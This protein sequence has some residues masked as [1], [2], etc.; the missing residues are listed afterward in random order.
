TL[1]SLDLAWHPHSRVIREDQ[2]GLSSARLRGIQE[3]SADL[4]VFVDDDNVLAQDYLWQAI[5]IEREWPMLGVWGSGVIAPEFEEEP[6]ENLRDYLPL[7]SLRYT[8]SAQWSNF[9]PDHGGLPWGAGQC[10]RAIVAA[11]YRDYFERPGI[12]MSDR[13]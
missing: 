4:L 6:A 2:L 11:A 7:L 3:A 5:R 13:Q 9:L 12:K 1:E 10:L 8:E